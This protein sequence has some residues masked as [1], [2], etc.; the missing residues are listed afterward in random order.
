MCAPVAP[1]IKC[2]CVCLKVNPTPPQ[3]PRLQIACLALCGQKSIGL[4]VLVR[5]KL[6]FGEKK[7][8]HKQ[9]EEARITTFAS[10]LWRRLAHYKLNWLDPLR[11]EIRPNSYFPPR[12][13]GQI[14]TCPA[15]STIK[16]T[17]PTYTH[18]KRL[19]RSNINDVH[20]HFK[21]SSLAPLARASGHV[22]S[23]RTT[24]TI[25]RFVRDEKWGRQ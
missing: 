17:F 3:S 20:Y 9:P 1:V 21:F 14:K 22:F 12:E 23:A 18:H 6:H 8:V 13:S 16:L 4:R 25:A 7:I 19:A 24:A 2:V 11:E 5:W 10:N 15:R